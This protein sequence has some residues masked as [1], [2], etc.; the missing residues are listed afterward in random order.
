[1]CAPLF[2]LRRCRV[3]LLQLPQRNI[4]RQAQR[5]E[6]GADSGM[7]RPDCSQSFLQGFRTRLC[8]PDHYKHWKYIKKKKNGN[9]SH[10]A[11]RFELG[12][13][14]SVVRPDRSESF[15]SETRLVPPLPLKKETG[16][17]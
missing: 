13:H 16:H 1:M 9:I 4:V 14:S 6:L 15:L 3:R 8:L 12:A 2:R 5:F 17:L 10:R 7:V 11:Q